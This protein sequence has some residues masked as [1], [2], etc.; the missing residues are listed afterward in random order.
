MQEYTELKTMTASQAKALFKFC[1]RMA[2][3]GENYRVGVI[4]VICPLCGKHPYGQD[5]SFD[6]KYSD[7]FGWTFPYKFQLLFFP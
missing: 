3:F 1:V 2:P 6:C 7:I 4:M 5:K